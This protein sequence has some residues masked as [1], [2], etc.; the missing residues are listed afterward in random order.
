MAFA[1]SKKQFGFIKRNN[2]KV[3]ENKTFYNVVMLSEDT[4]ILEFDQNQKSDKEP[5]K[6]M[7]IL[8]V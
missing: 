6:F 8:N 1:C 3:F 7:Q 4:K 2:I 5:F